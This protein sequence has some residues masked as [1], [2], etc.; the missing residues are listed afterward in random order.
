MNSLPS[1]SSHHLSNIELLERR[2][3]DLN[4]E[5]AELVKMRTE[6]QRGIQPG[7]VSIYDA[8]LKERGDNLVEVR[9]A[10]AKAKET[11]KAAPTLSSKPIVKAMSEGSK[12][13][14]GTLNKFFKKIGAN[15]R[16][17]D[18][19]GPKFVSVGSSG[20][21]VC[22]GCGKDC[23]NAGGRTEHQKYCVVVA[24]NAERLQTSRASR[25][26][27]NPLPS[28]SSSAAAASSVE[29]QRVPGEV[30]SRERNVRVEMGVGE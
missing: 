28:S 8:L 1:S 24:E 7:I 20:I 27:E 2:A 3:E 14:Q 11:T 22:N 4:V 19:E 6:V 9:I 13:V 23:V 12:L 17:E 25:R 16:L 30:I 26:E 15:N 10:L 18:L 5:I 29:A 21:H